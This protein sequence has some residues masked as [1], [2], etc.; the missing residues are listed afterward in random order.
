[1]LVSLRLRDGIILD[2]IYIGH[3]SVKFFIAEIRQCYLRMVAIVVLCKAK[4]ELTLRCHDNG[5]FCASEKS[6]SQH[7]HILILQ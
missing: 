2:V 5:P 3:I 4:K 7:I 1:M 6:L